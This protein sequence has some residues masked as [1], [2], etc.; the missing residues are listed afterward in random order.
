MARV[1]LVEQEA[2]E[3]HYP[4]QVGPRDINTGGHLGYDNL[5]SLVGTA[6]AHVLH[7]LGLTEIDLG[8]GRTS[9]VMGDLSV[10]YRGEAF[11]FDNLVIDTHVGKITRTGFRMFHRVTKGGSLIALMETGFVSFNHKL[12]RVAPVPREF[13]EAQSSRQP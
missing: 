6:R 4:W 5:V 9:L 1:K 8:D 2:Y 3:F 10:N 12:K 7:S 11:M 13:L